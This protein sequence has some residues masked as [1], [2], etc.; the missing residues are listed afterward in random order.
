MSYRVILMKLLPKKFESDFLD[1]NLYLNTNAYFGTI[2]H[3]DSVRFDP[4]DGVDESRQASKIE[5]RD[6]NGDWL[7]LPI[8]G[9]IT[10][11]SGGSAGLNVLCLFAVTDRADDPFDKR[12][13]AFGDVAVVIDDLMEFI[14][15][16]KA[17]AKGANKQV[18]HGPIQ[19]VERATHDGPMGPFRKYTEHSYQNEFRFVF[20]KG[21]GEPS[22]LPIGNIRDITHSINTTDVPL[23]WEEMLRFGE[24]NA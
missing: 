14:R 22:R 12:N 7:P 18:L 15:R 17:A 13:L 11:R 24:Q 8:M 3:T 4:H 21:T 20:T 16:I 10:M 2:D 19:Y 9:P 23:F 6:E 1:G 5:I